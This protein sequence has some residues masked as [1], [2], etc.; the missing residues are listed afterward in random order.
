MFKYF[1]MITSLRHIYL[2]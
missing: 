1:N 2:L